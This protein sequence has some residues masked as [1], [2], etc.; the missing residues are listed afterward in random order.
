MRCFLSPSVAAVSLTLGVP[1]VSWAPAADDTCR[2][3]A[4]APQGLVMG[5]VFTAT[6]FP[7]PGSTFNADEPAAAYRG[8]FALVRALP[9]APT[10]VTATPGDA[11][12][13]SPGRRPPTPAAARS[14]RTRSPSTP[15]GPVL[16]NVTSPTTVTG[17][18]NG[19]DYTFSVY[20]ITDAGIGEAGASNTVTP[21]PAPGAPTGVT[22]TPGNGQV[23]VSFTPP[24]S[25]GGSAIT[26]YTVTAQ[27]G[28][29]TVPRHRP[30]RSSSTGYERPGLHV[31]GHGHELVRHLG[32]VGAVEL[33]DAA[34]DPR[35]A[36]RRLGHAR[37]RTGDC[38]LHGARLERRRAV[39][40]YTAT[41]SPDGL[42]GTSTDGG[43]I[44]VSGLVNGGATRSRSRPRTRPG[45]GPR[46]RRRTR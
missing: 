14:P 12:R 18:T 42:T 10:N 45:P 39:T 21:Q 40:L 25:S 29:I 22:G 19:N 17:L 13:R 8:G 31:H 16:T 1:N 11:R 28:N 20:A 7:P 30:A 5:G 32:G 4:V 36:D 26:G 34:H 6:G 3:L 41:S 9:D 43:D 46:R 44:V 24:A 37:Q 27:P 35:R 23:S 2:A 38:E 33:G 15:D